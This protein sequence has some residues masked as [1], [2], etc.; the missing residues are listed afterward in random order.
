MDLTTRTVAAL[1]ASVFAVTANASAQ[2]PSMFH[3][4]APQVRQTLAAPQAETFVAP[5]WKPV[6]RR[7]ILRKLIGGILGGIGGLYAGGAIGAKLYELHKC[8]CDDPAFQGFLIGAPIG[9]VIGAIAG[10][11]LA[12]R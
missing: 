4:S 2:T 8:E 10:V 7:H 1:V 6:P 11:K 12:S 9:A 5:Q 3:L